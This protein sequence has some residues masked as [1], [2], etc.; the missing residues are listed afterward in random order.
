VQVLSRSAGGRGACR[1]PAPVEHPRH[2]VSAGRQRALA[3]GAAPRV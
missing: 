2:D 1:A 3:H